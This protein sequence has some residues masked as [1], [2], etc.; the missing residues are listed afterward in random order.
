VAFIDEEIAKLQGGIG[1]IEQ[2]KRKNEI[3]EDN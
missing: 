3:G 2:S 1:M